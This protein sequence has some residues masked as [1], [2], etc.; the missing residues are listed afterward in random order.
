MYEADAIAGNQNRKEKTLFLHQGREAL[1]NKL[2]KSFEQACE[3]ARN[4]NNSLLKS[5][6]PISN[7]IIQILNCS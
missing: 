4:P 7:F 2:L 5:V 3:I 1:E 6:L